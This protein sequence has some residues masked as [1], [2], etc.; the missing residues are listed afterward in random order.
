VKSILDVVVISHEDDVRDLVSDL[1]SKMS[2]IE[3]V[4]V[5]DQMTS[6]EKH[7]Q[8]QGADFVLLDADD[9]EVD[10][11]L[12]YKRIR[13]LRPDIKIALMSRGPD[14]AIKGYEVGV[15]DYLL[16]PVK[17]SQLARI[18]RKCI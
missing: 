13:S 11:I 2:D 9:G 17:E 12:P 18:I 8:L 4:S 7:L 6:V 1:L 16:K 5:F 15:W 14:A 10:W 3:K